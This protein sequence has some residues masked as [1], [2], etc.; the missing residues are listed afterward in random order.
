[1]L[2]LIVFRIYFNLKLF[3]DSID[4]NSFFLSVTERLKTLDSVSHDT[5]CNQ[6]STTVSNSNPSL[7]FYSSPYHQY[8]DRFFF[9]CNQMI[10]KFK[11]FP[12]LITYRNQ[13]KDKINT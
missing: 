1:M 2:N 3:I 13:N 8:F 6:S 10:A 4:K 11:E 7:T 9:K 12:H 5:Q